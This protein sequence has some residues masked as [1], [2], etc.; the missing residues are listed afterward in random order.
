MAYSDFKQLIDAKS[1]E[2]RFGEIEFNLTDKTHSKLRDFAW[3][4][5][6]VVHTQLLLV[7]D[8]RFQSEA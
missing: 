8:S 6:A 2:M 1:V 4:D 3:H 5:H 7:F